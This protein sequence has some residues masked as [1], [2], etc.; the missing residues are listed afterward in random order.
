MDDTSP[1]ATADVAGPAE[2]GDLADP[3]SA[4]RDRAALLAAAQPYCLE[5][6]LALA[7][8]DALRLHGLPAPVHGT[9]LLLVTAGGPPL[10]DLAAGLAETL[11][12]AGHRVRQPPGSARRRQLAVSTPAADPGEPPLG[13]PDGTAV[14]TATTATAATAGE[15]ELGVELRR[16]P[17]RHPPTLP[18]AA[19]DDTAALAVL[20]LCERALPADLEAVHA[21]TAHRREG[22][23]LALASAFDEDFTTRT[24]ADRLETAAALL[25]PETDTAGTRRWAEA[26]AQDLRL[27]LLETTELADG[28]HDPYLDAHQD[29]AD[30]LHDPYLDA[31]QDRADPSDPADP[32]DDL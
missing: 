29:R 15:P 30:G 26:W 28:L 18:V 11:R 14:T 9:G 31:H 21:L 2:P 19:L 7:G 6:A 10:A 20:T 27:D 4:D 16:E 23:L 3:G 25:P 5:H 13:S 32:T 1:A 17:L 12:A 22:E 8:P 24:L